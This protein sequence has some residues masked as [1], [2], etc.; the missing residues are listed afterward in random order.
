MPSAPPSPKV[1]CFGPFE[2]DLVAGELR[3]RGRKVELQDQPFH[4]LALL[5][6]RRN[7]LVTREELRQE[8]WSA[9]SFVDF[10]ESLNKA[11]QKV[12]HALGD[13]PDNPHFI[14]T[15]PRKGYRFIASVREIDNEHKGRRRKLLRRILGAVAVAVLAAGTAWLWNARSKARKPALTGVPFTT[16]PGVE[17]CPSFSPDGNQIA[18]TWDGAKQDNLDIYIKLIGAENELRLT[19]DPAQDTHPAWSPDGRVIAFVRSLPGGTFGIYLIPA[20]GGAERKVAVT[21]RLGVPAW[22]PDGK[23]LVFSDKD[24]ANPADETS[25]LRAVSIE[26]GENHRL[27][28][29][30]RGRLDRRLFSRWAK[31]GFPE[32]KEALLQRALSAEAYRGYQPQIRAETDHVPGRGNRQPRMDSRWARDRLYRS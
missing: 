12:R 10:D 16:Y 24:T 22:S 25:S 14:E 17:C 7:E 23:W 32:G 28:S 13:S 27:T 9:D 3:K 26:S 4:V 11:V 5:L 20:I 29:A 31:S 2:V 15:I 30:P 18:F 8:L 6:R 19:R 21:G 1:V